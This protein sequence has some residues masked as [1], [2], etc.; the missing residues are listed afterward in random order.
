MKWLLRILLYLSLTWLLVS[1]DFLKTSLPIFPFYSLDIIFLSVVLSLVFSDNPY[2]IAM[3]SAATLIKDLFSAFPLG[4]NSLLMTLSL[5]FTSWILHRIF[6]NRSAVIIAL[7][8]F[9]GMVTY[10]LSLGLVLL[11]LYA[12][13]HFPFLVTQE[14]LTHSLSEIL[15]TSAAAGIAYFFIHLG[16]KRFRPHYVNFKQL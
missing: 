10:K 12:G 2:I 11:L 13:F 14:N 1:L 5:I 6:T 8:T 4:V 7:S 9:I 15:V 3:A 16:I